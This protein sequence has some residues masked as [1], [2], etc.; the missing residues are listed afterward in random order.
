LNNKFKAFNPEVDMANPTFKAGR[1]FSGVE[2]LRKALATYTIRNR[3]PIRK[4]KND[5]IRLNVV[6]ADGCPWM[7]KASADSREGGFCIIV[8]SELHDLWAIARSTSVPKWEKNMEKLKVDS[9]AA[10]AWIEHLVPNTWIKAFF[11]RFS[12]V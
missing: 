3:V 6:C 9:E 10:Y 2:E 5:R 11:L 12:K 7:L 8:Y 4:V 1:K